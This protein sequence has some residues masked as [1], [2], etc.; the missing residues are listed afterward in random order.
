MYIYVQYTYVHY[1]HTYIQTDK[2]NDSFIVRHHHIQIHRTHIH[3]NRQAGRQT[4][5]MCLCED[6]SL[7][8]ASSV[9][10][11]LSHMRQALVATPTSHGIM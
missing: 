8:V 11:F 4:D 7:V 9:P 2:H 10:F 6:L 1:I 5:L 3:T